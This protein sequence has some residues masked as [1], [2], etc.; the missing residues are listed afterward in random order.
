MN[1]RCPYPPRR[2]QRCGEPTRDEEALV[3]GEVWCHSCADRPE[4]E[5]L[6]GALLQLVVD[7][8]A[9]LDE[10][11]EDWEVIG[12]MRAIAREALGLVK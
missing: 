3:G 4:L 9:S 10:P 5:R 6:R 1:G 7:P 12:K 11:D 8:P 2:C